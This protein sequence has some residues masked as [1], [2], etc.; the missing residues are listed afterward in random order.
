MYNH[1]E[2]IRI[3]WLCHFSNSFVHK[4][5]D[6][7]YSELTKLVKRIIGKPTS[8]VIPEFANWINNGI[9]E[10]EKLKDVELH[11]VSP[12]P[13]LQKE[14]QQ[15][16]SNGIYYHFFKNEDLELKIFLYKKLFHPSNYRYHLNRSR[17]HSLIDAIQPDI[18]HL[19][20]AENPYYASAVLDD[21]GKSIII[22]QLQTL[23]SD[24]IFRDNYPID[25]KSY[26]Y[27]AHIEKEIIKK[28]D[29]IGV[30]VSKY[31]QIISKDINPDAVF[32]NIG[33]ALKDPIVDQ[34]CDKLYDFVYVAANINKAVDLAIEAFSIVHKD[35]PQVKL[36]I[37][38]GYDYEFKQ[39]IDA[40]IRDYN[41]KDV[42]TFEGTLP[43]HD[44]VLRQIRK[45]RFALLPLKVDITSGTIREAMS[46]G[47]PVI[48]TDTGEG[49]T[50]K[51]NRVRE[52]VLISPIGDHQALANNMVRLLDDKVLADTLRRNAYQTRAEGRS[53]ED[54]ILRYVEAYKACIAHSRA[55]IPLPTSV[56]V[57]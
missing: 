57:V 32:L 53:N 12:Y 30:T 54:T 19:F 13:H 51:L 9:S 18:I 5:L 14:T 44:D 22:A 41:L 38:G 6:W 27:R 42:I 33:L 8:P 56:T 46:N 49:G 2:K 4:N 52:N 35:R 15:L 16:I 37:I 48:T 47:L 1:K 24:P 10:M 11:I 25:S 29:Y 3:V 34:D 26:E 36:D 40:L 39:Y 45:S 55:G 17:I 7:G 23:M 21:Y 28:A 50:L 43:T 20:G 31:R